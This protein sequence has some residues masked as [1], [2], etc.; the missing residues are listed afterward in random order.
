M[1]EYFTKQSVLNIGI[2]HLLFTPASKIKKSL[3]NCKAYLGVVIYN[4]KLIAQLLF[5]NVL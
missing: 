3:R 4:S 2:K 1:K 5:F